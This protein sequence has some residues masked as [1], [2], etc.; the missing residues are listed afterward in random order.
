LFSWTVHGRKTIKEQNV[1]RTIVITGASSGIGKATALLFAERGWKVVATMRDAAKSPFAAV[2]DIAVVP[3]D[4]TDPGSV[5]AAARAV[6]GISPRVDVLLNNAGY[7]LHGVLEGY[8]REQIDAQLRTNVI[9]LIDVVRA[10]LPMMRAQGGGTIVNVASMGGRIGFPLYSMY[11]ASKFAVEG[12]TEALSYELE[13]VGIR[14]RLIEPGVIRTDFY[15]RS[16]KE[17][18]APQIPDY[19]AFVEKALAANER[20][21]KG[22][23]PPEAAARVIYRAATSRGARLRWVVGSDARLVLFLRSVL[24]FRAFHALFRRVM[25]G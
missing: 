23:S 6:A 7:A 16:M 8:T 21:G 13:P 14:L 2:P 5:S 25:I 1:A 17:A 11:Q 24:P 15:T 12:F 10:F 19:S 18:E 20:M 22:G 4:V 3:L 9:G